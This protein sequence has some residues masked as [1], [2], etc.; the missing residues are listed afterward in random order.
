MVV[1]SGATLLSN[2]APA[3]EPQRAQLFAPTQTKLL[4]LGV[5]T[6]GL[7]LLLWMYRNWRGLAGARA[8]PLW[9]EGRMAFWPFSLAWLFRAL[10][11][12]SGGFGAA[13]AMG[14]A[15]LFL[16]LFAV[17]AL[18]N[19]WN[20]LAPLLVLPLLPVNARM[21]RARGEAALPARPHEH[22]AVWQWI[23]AAL[24]GAFWLL[25]LAGS[26]LAMLLRMPP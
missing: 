1:D 7:Y 8:R 24:A 6:G 18:P 9:V 12:A 16:L 3:A 21:R 10:G 14:W 11:R 4:V 19:G 20:V 15:A 13:W 23:W 2:S 5:T 17:C 26:V 25:T 22:M